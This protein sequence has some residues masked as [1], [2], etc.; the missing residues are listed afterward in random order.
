MLFRLEVKL[1][2][3]PTYI[4]VYGVSTIMTSSR[5]KEMAQIMNLTFVSD[6]AGT[7]SWII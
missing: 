2:I 3:Y 5:N 7:D 1:F 6:R 4:E